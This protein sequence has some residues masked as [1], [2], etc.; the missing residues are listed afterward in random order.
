MRGS[1]PVPLLCTS[2]YRA[3]SE[4]AHSTASSQEML[5][6]LKEVRAK[7]QPSVLTMIGNT[8]PARG[9]IPS[10]A[11]IPP[12]EGAVGPNSAARGYGGCRG[13]TARFFRLP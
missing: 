8:T 12:S 9:L 13:P 7:Q 4:Y 3:F 2:Y 10:C 6:T 5:P 11:S 1:D